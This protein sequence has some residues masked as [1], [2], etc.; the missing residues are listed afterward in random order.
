MENHL[1]MCLKEIKRDFYL[2]SIIF[3]HFIDQFVNFGKNT[4]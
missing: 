1:R 4:I 3:I 2:R